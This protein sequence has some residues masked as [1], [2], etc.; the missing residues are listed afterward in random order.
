MNSF[1]KK[2]LSRKTKKSIDVNYLNEL[3]KAV[4]DNKLAA[5]EAI[6]EMKIYN[7]LCDIIIK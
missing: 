3:D 7:R 1:I 4:K 6:V 5:E 2:L